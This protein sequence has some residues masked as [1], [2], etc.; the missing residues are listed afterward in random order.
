MLG[1]LA[2]T[3]GLGGLSL[4]AWWFVVAREMPGKSWARR[5]AQGLVVAMTA[6][7]VSLTGMTVSRLPCSPRVLLA[8][9]LGTALLVAV[10]RRKRPPVPV[11][12]RSDRWAASLAGATLVPL[13]VPFLG[14]SSGQVLHLLSRTTDG[15]THLQLVLALARE[16]GYFHLTQPSGLSPGAEHYPLGWAA[17]VWFVIESLYGSQSTL[18]TTLQVAGL[19]TV[20]LYAVVVFLAA[21]I[22]FDCA[23]AFTRTAGLAGTLVLGLA[24]SVGFGIFLLQLNAYT[25][26]VAALAILVGIEATRSS[27]PATR[28]AVILACTAVLAAQSWYL[29]APACGAVVIAALLQV[30]P[31]RRVL[32]T[33]T[34][35]AGPFCL[36]PVLVGPPAGRQVGMD[37]PVFVPTAAGLIGLLVALL[38]GLAFL[39]R[40]LGGGERE[41]RRALAIATV[42]TL[43]EAA[44][45]IA[46]DSPAGSVNYYGAKLLLLALLLGSVASAAA[47]S[48]GLSRALSPRRASLATIAVAG[49]LLGAVSTHRMTVPPTSGKIHPKLDEGLLETFME[50][51]PDGLTP[52][53]DAWFVN[54]CYR[55][56]DRISTKWAY[57]LSLTW[58]DSRV[59]RLIDYQNADWGDVS[60]IAARVAEPSVDTVELY[61]G[62]DCQHDAIASL[63]RM[64]KVVVVRAP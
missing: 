6:T 55:L 56:A 27:T 45:I 11:A 3:L 40:G 53:Q 36:Y 34:T 28:G 1:L 30:R 23:G 21:A 19:S 24:L 4:L 7:V 37:G 32:L 13:L 63:A 12:N 48:S 20:L 47:V 18:A 8:A 5:A 50:R 64:P 46:T 29:V 52:T 61:V 10:F 15:G 60:M 16:R 62:R 49:M 22:A 17:N 54:G 39:L 9:L 58:T 31:S 44:L 42:T 38:V 14:A 59:L 26:I 35:V 43:V 41:L 2:L 25:L 33:I 57:D 51:H